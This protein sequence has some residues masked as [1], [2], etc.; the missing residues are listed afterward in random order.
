MGD[1]AAEFFSQLAQFSG[2]VFEFLGLPNTVSPW[3]A[4]GFPPGKPTGAVLHY[5]GSRDAYSSAMW[6]MKSELGAKVSAHVIIAADWPEGTRERFGTGLPLVQELPTMVLQCVPPGQVSYHATW[7]NDR[8]FGVELVNWG[9]IRW[10]P[11]AGWVVYPKNWAQRYQARGM[12][13]P[14]R[15]LGRYW[16]PFPA[17]Q[18]HC[19]VEILRWYRRLRAGALREAW[20][21]GHEQVQGVA[22][23]GAGGDKR[24]PGPFFPIQDVR[25]AAFT[26][27]SVGRSD[28]LQRYRD[29]PQY[30]AKI[31][32]GMVLDWYLAHT[33]GAVVDERTGE[34]AQ[35]KLVQE[36]Y[37]MGAAHPWGKTFGALGKLCLQLLGYYVQ[38]PGDSV[39]GPLDIE[40]IR[41]F[42]RMVGI[43]GDGRPGYVTCHEIFSRLVDRGII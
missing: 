1:G 10:D 12:A 37:A 11:K 39:L 27:E 38:H 43:Q 2:R 32:A 34:E 31:R 26:D 24:D 20:I 8:S 9:E 41:V 14:Q 18:V 6:F 13:F 21:L 4:A 25:A 40:A 28:W 16:E 29:D 36:V 35:K 3:V 33:S 7:C 17:E 15:A 23:G 19:A 5:T 30:V 42:Q 22:T